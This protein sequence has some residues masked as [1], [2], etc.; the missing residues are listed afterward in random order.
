MIP[1]HNLEKTLTIGFLNKKI[2]DNLEVYKQH[3]DIVLTKENATFC[4]VEKIIKEGKEE[5]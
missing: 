2:E 1:K 4:E 3:Y 5:S